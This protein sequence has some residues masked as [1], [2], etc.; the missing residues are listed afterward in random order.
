MPIFHRRSCPERS[1][2]EAAFSL[3]EFTVVLGVIGL[4][5]GLLWAFV[6]VAWDM[7][8]REIMVEN[9]STVVTNIR[10]TYGGQTGMSTQST[11]AL[12]PALFANGTIPYSMQRPPASNCTNLH[13]LCAD[14]P[15]ENNGD[16]NGTFQICSWAYGTQSPLDCNPTAPAGS[17]SQF[18]GIELKGL[19]QDNC[20]KLAA[21]ITGSTTIRGIAGSYINATSYPPPILV[22]T[23]KAVCGSGYTNN[24]IFVYSLQ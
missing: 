13:N 17:S 15:W 19:S 24:L 6:S 14:T 5:L 7:A 2:P 20:I 4:I 8:R 10:S 1:G 21:Q 3:M 18:F 22:Q 11:T 16:P 12:V 9:V 23:A